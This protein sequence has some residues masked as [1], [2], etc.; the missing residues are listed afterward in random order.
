M[1]N[2]IFKLEEAGLNVEEKKK[3]AFESAMND[4]T[5]L[6]ESVSST[7]SSS[8]QPAQ[9]T[10]EETMNMLIS[11]GKLVK[12]IEDDQLKRYDLVTKEKNASLEAENIRNYV[13]KNGKLLV[14]PAILAFVGWWLVVPIVIA[15]IWYFKSYKNYKENYLNEH[16]AE[17]DANADEYIE[18]NVVPIQNE[19]KAIDEKIDKLYAEGDVQCAKEFIGE[20][21]FVYGIIEDLYGLIKSNRADSLKEALNLYD[22]SLHKQRMEEMQAAIQNASEIQANE[23]AK[24]TAYQK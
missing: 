12:Q 11:V 7:S 1:R 13:P 2:I 16:K 4:N 24:Q 21:N 23:A 8:I 20:D 18:K 14:G 3:S 10:R 17:N 9:M 6:Y 5:P 22:D 15:I 19:I